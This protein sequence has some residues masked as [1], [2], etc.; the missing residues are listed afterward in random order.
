MLRAEP[1]TVNS[2]VI[3]ERPER[4]ECCRVTR[5]S[6]SLR[7]MQRG[8]F[9]DG[10]YHVKAVKERM[11]SGERG[12]SNRGAGRERSLPVVY[13]LVAKLPRREPLQ[14]RRIASSDDSQVPGRKDNSKDV[15]VPKNT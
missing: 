13:F 9:G 12:H 14:L 15:M 1:A 2:C 5:R 3:S 10:R 11:Q 4:S 8:T 7:A 6:G